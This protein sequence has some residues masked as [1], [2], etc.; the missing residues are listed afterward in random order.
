[1]KKMIQNVLCTAALLGVLAMPAAAQDAASKPAESAAPVAASVT[2]AAP[3][4]APAAPDAAAPASAAEAAA[5]A[6]PA[7]AA[8]ASSSAGFASSSYRLDSI[9]RPIANG[10]VEF[11]GRT[12]TSGRRLPQ[13]YV[14]S[15]AAA[16]PAPAG[17]AGAG[18]A[19][20]SSSGWW[21]RLRKI[22]RAHV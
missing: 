3:A 13:A 11:N 5:P 21:G 15:V 7:A 2:D 10:T 14:D 22:G 20:S 17:G 4:S 8:A 16:A 12:Y 6:A 1:M 18:F 19:S 9:G